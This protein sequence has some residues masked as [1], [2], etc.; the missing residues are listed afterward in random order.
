MDLIDFRADDVSI[1]AAMNRIPS[2]KSV[3]ATA[4]WL[5]CTPLRIERADVNHLDK[6]YE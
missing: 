4:S 6:L 3:P 2:A 5:L 1:T